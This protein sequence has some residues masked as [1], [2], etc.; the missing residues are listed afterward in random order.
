MEH[1]STLRAFAE[2]NGMSVSEVFSLGR[3]KGALVTIN[4]GNGANIYIKDDV[5]KEK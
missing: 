1:Y 5:L 4:K 3:E 2:Q